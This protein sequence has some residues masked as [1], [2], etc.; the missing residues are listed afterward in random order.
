M[1]STK[2]ATVHSQPGD[3]CNLDLLNAAGIEYSIDRVQLTHGLLCL[4]GWC[5]SRFNKH[6]S[7][8]IILVF[9]D[10]DPQEIPLDCQLER[11]DVSEKKPELNPYCG[12]FLYATIKQSKTPQKILFRIIHDN[13][14]PIV[15]SLPFAHAGTNTRPSQKKSLLFHYLS[16]AIAHVRQ[17]NWRLLAERARTSWPVLFAK[18]AKHDLIASL[19]NSLPPETILIV[20]HTLGGGANHYRDTLIGEHLS[21]NHNVLLWTFSPVVLSF[22][23]DFISPSNKRQSYK[24]DFSTWDALIECQQIAELIFNNA[25]SYPQP[26]RVPETL[27]RFLSASKQKR[28]LTLLVH[29]FFMVCP[30]HFL[31]NNKGQYCK[32]PDIDQC[33]SCLP[34]IETP[35][36]KLFDPRDIKLWRSL[37]LHTL[38]LAT[39]IVCFSNNSRSLLLRA[40]PELLE[41]RIQVRPHRLD[42]CKGNY[43]YPGPGTP[44]R[45]AIVGAIGQHKGSDQFVA[46][47][48]AGRSRA[49]DIQ[50]FVIGSLIHREKPENIIETGPYQRSQLPEFLQK[51]SIHI[52]LVLS[53]CPETFSYVTHELIQLGVPL[54]TY[55]IGAQG[56]AVQHY[57]LGRAVEL[58]DAQGLLETIFDF[59]NELDRMYQENKPHIV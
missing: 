22:Q 31:I 19:L 18:R 49:H 8:S 28:R 45:V 53:I 6:I 50:F 13:T 38:Q 9:S 14:N 5:A 16:R 46:L 12:F 59:K 37:W 15:I 57:P 39:E 41:Q 21:K 27:S 54:I 30:S 36:T 51:F 44:I 24:V 10:S 48:N 26:E 3:L 55:A 47:A 56:E 25:V 52:A 7:A 23:L 2:T 35:L 11:P 42:Y 20:D 58:T 4:M 34:T 17:G 32:I 43:H 29:D 40:Y 33:Q 1:Q